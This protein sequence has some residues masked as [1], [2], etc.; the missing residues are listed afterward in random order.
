MHHE[1]Q[2]QEGNRVS[3]VLRDIDI[4]SIG[5]LDSEK[6][7]FSY[8][9]YLYKNEIVALVSQLRQDYADLFEAVV[10]KIEEEEAAAEKHIF[11]AIGYNSIYHRVYDVEFKKLGHWN[12]IR[13]FNSWGIPLGNQ[14]YRVPAEMS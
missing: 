13:E 10:K 12:A 1:I 7:H 11:Y 8:L 2:R 14:L 5:K 9:R 3:Y 4:E 6:A